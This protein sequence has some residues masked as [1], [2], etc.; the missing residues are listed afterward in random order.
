MPIAFSEIYD[1]IKDWQVLIAAVLIIAAGRT[2]VNALTRGH[3]HIAHSVA[4]SSRHLIEAL[5]GREPPEQASVPAPAPGMRGIIPSRIA[6][7]TER[8]S[9]REP[10]IAPGPVPAAQPAEAGARLDALRDVIRLALSIIPVSEIPLSGQGARL[11]QKIAD[12][13]FDDLRAAG[14]GNPDRERLTADLESELAALRGHEPEEIDCR[15]AWQSLV[16]INGLSRELREKTSAAG[17]LEIV[18]KP[19]EAIEKISL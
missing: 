16:R 11:Y 3:L 7:S 15:T 12:F 1:W 19:A 13:S 10:T 14:S 17:P 6:P 5:A 18:P 9:L 4:Q 2:W 8:A